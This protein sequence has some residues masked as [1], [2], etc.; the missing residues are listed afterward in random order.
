MVV[1]L[2]SALRKGWASSPMLKVLKNTRVQ[3]LVTN[4]HGRV[5]GVRYAT[6][7]KRGGAEESGI[8][9]SGNVVLATGGYANDFEEGSLLQQYTPHLMKFPTTNG[10]W[11]SGDGHKFATRDVD[12]KLVDMDK[13][14]VHPTAFVNPEHPEAKIKTLCA[15]ILR[16]MEK[17]IGS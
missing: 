9:T 12:A 15:E 14:Q 16:G 13:V 2:D 11:A 4:E 8:L 7:A 10:R 5:T 3:G 6:K 1:A 17:K